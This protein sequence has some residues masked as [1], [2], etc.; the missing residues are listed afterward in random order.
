[1]TRREARRQ[2]AEQAS[3]RGDQRHLVG[4]TEGAKRRWRRRGW[5]RDLRP[6]ERLRPCRGCSACRQWPLTISAYIMRPW[7]WPCSSRDPFWQVSLADGTPCRL[8]HEGDHAK[9]ALGTPA[10]G[11]RRVR[12]E[13]QYLSTISTAICDG[14]GVLP[15][16]RRT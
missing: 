11:V 7:G 8:I 14:T 1:M 16:R 6:G 2:H 10:G 3:A 13:W 5:T 9:V 15:A 4:M 12:I